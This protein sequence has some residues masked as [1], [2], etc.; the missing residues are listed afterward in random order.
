MNY[1]FFLNNLSFEQFVNAFKD[2]QTLGDFSREILSTLFTA[3]HLISG[4]ATTGAQGTTKSGDSAVQT[5]VTGALVMAYYDTESTAIIGEDAKI[6]QL[7]TYQSPLQ[8]VSVD[9]KTRYRLL[10]SAGPLEPDG[11]KDTIK[12][13][14]GTN[15][16]G[17]YGIGG[18]GIVNDFKSHTEATIRRGAMVRT[19]SDQDLNVKANEDLFY[20]AFALQ[21]SKSGGLGIAGSFNYLDQDSTTIAHVQDGVTI[22]TGNLQVN[23]IS[24]QQ[25]VLITGG[26]QRGKSVGA[27]VSI[28][29]VE[30]ERDVRAI[31]GDDPETQ[32]ICMPPKQQASQQTAW[33]CMLTQRAT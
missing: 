32:T 28:S 24:N 26:V 11:P 30:A 8:S 3:I 33:M 1:P 12:G 25:E 13:L 18:A 4:G 5:A 17:K 23:A 20:G 10:N 16:A 15:E 19:G 9:A 6:N 27:G 2:K 21:S 14:G 22:A 29:I 31:V 7:A